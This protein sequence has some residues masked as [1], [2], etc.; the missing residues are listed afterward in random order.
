MITILCS[1]KTR[2]KVWAY[3]WHAEVSLDQNSISI[4]VW[5]KKKIASFFPRGSCLYFGASVCE[6]PFFEGNQIKRWLLL[7]H[8]QP[9]AQW[10]KA[11]SMF[12]GLRAVSSTFVV[13]GTISSSSSWLQSRPWIASS[14]VPAGAR[15]WKYAFLRHVASLLKMVIQFSIRAVC[16]KFTFFCLSL[17]QLPA[18]KVKLLWGLSLKPCVNRLFLAEQLND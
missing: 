18:A 8:L 9:S 10:Y 1:T 5:H 2:G 13:T 7:P 4:L 17:E 6:S 16:W 14:A 12:P 11:A 3:C 15:I